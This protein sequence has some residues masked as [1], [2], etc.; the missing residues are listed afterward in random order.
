MVRKIPDETREQ[1]LRLCNE[2][3]FRD[4][5]PHEIVPQLALE[6][7]YVASERTMYRILK[8]HSQ[9][10]HRS[11][12]RVRGRRDKPPQ[13]TATGPDQVYTWEITWMAS[14]VK[15]LFFYAY[16]IID[17][18]KS[19]SAAGQSTRMRMSVTVG[20]CSPD[21]CGDVRFASRPC[22]PTTGTL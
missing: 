17:I 9:L 15:G 7:H 16:V 21:C 1:I 13:R 20:T 6:G 18:L 2:P 12:S 5:T 14:D 19:R 22:T 3:R 11:E 10:H 8:Q 4:L